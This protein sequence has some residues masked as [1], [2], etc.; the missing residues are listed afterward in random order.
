MRLRFKQVASP[1]DISAIERSFCD[2]R[3]CIGSV[4]G[5]EWGIDVSPNALSN[6]FTHYFML[7]FDGEDVRGAYQPL[8]A[9]LAFLERLKPFSEDILLVDYKVRNDD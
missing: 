7:N 9:H 2:L 4:R 5:L 6:R 1:S 8:P 3:Q